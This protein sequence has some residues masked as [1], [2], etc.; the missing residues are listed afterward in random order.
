MMPYS[1]NIRE[2]Q[3]YQPCI[4]AVQAK[5]LIPAYLGTDAVDEQ[6]T[7]LFDSKPTDQLVICSDFSRFDQHFNKN[8]QNAAREVLSSVI[9]DN[10]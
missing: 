1:L 4:E 5:R 9:N 8:M 3:I 7:K 10:S 2:L 6:V